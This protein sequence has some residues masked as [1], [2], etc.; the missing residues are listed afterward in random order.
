MI[1]LS[2][3]LIVGIFTALVDLEYSFINETPDFWDAAIQFVLTVI[4]WPITLL[5]LL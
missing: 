3:Y 4:F 5:F 2:I 1:A